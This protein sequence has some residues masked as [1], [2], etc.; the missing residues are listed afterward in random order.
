MEPDNNQDNVRTANN[1]HI[2]DLATQEGKG[3][4]SANNPIYSSATNQDNVQNGYI[5][6]ETNNNQDDVRNGYPVMEPDNNQDNVRNGYI[7]VEPNNQDNVRNGYIVVEPDDDKS[8]MIEKMK[9]NINNNINEINN[10]II[11]NEYFYG[12]GKLVEEINDLINKLG[13][14][15]IKRIR[16]MINMS[17]DESIYGT[18]AEFKN[19]Y[20]KNKGCSIM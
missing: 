11:Y 19:K 6:V 15:S 8:K 9:N 5:D 3:I 14:N 20:R 10:L 4:R 18:R 13:D 1:G 17:L 2:Y 16:K 7:D 12:T